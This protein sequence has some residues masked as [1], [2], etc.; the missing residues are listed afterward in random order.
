MTPPATTV[1]LIAGY[2]LALVAVGWSFDAMARRASAHASRKAGSFRQ[3]TSVRL[4]APQARA[5]VANVGCARSAA[6]APSCLLLSC[7]PCPGL[8]ICGHPLPRAAPALHGLDWVC[9]T[10]GG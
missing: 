5:A 6:M 7:S 9:A 3:R 2:S 8:A 1:C 10:R 4:L